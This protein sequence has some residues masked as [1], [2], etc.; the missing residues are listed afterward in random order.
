VPLICLHFFPTL[1][2]LRTCNLLPSQYSTNT[3]T[4]VQVHLYNIA[5]NKMELALRKSPGGDPWGHEKVQTVV[6]AWGL[7]EAEVDKLRDL[8]S[9]LSDIKHWKNE[10]A[11]VVKFLFGPW[12]FKAAESMF[13]KMIEWRELNHVDEILE[14]YVPPPALLQNT[15]NTVLDDYDRDGD[16]IF[17]EAAGAVDFDLLKLFGRDEVLKCAIWGRELYTRGAWLD[18]FEQRQ[19]RSIKAVTVVYDLKGL[20]SK[21]LDPVALSIFRDVVK[22]AKENYPTK[23]KRV[24]IIRAPPIFRLIWNVAKHFFR[25][26]L[27]DKMVFAGKD[28]LEVLN[29]HVDI[30]ILPECI[31]PGGRGRPAAGLPGMIGCPAHKGNPKCLESWQTSSTSTARTTSIQSFLSEESEG[32]DDDHSMSSGCDA[33]VR[34]TH[35][36]KGQWTDSIVSVLPTISRSH[37]SFHE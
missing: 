34:T 24:I 11:T 32:T 36:S 21:H 7:T 9:R 2:A 23:V 20:S 10:P 29:K 37:S 26:T 22:L 28:Y 5:T 35:L 33:G 27:R 15:P 25:Q 13:R 31:Y 18:A 1:V 4:G 8:Q 14:T 3:S 19:R 16:P 17:L 30:H 12:G 6:D